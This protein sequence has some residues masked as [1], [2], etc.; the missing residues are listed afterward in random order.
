MEKGIPALDTIDVYAQTQGR[1]DAERRR[2]PE[3]DGQ[4]RRR[5]LQRSD[6]RP[7]DGGQHGKDLAAD[8]H[9]DQERDCRTG[10]PDGQGHGGITPEEAAGDI[11]TVPTRHQRGGKQYFHGPPQPS[12]ANFD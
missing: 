9:G 10:Q 8:Q 4:D 3:R 2:K 6:N 7:E 1:R 5:Q 12:L 11:V